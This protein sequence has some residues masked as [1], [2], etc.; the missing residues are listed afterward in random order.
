VG[1][2]EVPRMASA[3][4]GS[5]Y[6]VYGKKN[7]GVFRSFNFK[8]SPF[9]AAANRNMQRLEKQKKV[10]KDKERAQVFSDIDQF[11]C[12]LATRIGHT[13]FYPAIYDDK[14]LD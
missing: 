3:K 11:E 10:P 6:G 4:T 9:I 13:R 7:P 5:I 14:K 1:Q 8:E 12:G 2:E